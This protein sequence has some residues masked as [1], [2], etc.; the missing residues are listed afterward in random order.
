MT[1]FLITAQADENFLHLQMAEKMH[2]KQLI[3]CEFKK[4]KQWEETGIERLSDENY[5]E[6]QRS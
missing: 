2:R 3:A 4:R 6:A 1:Q 5:Q